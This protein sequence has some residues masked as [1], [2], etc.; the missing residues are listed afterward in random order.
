[1]DISVLAG[2][3]D[4]K[5]S[6]EGICVGEGRFV[7]ERMLH[8][9]LEPLV[10]A[11]VPG[12]LAGL[13]Q[14][15][16][17]PL[18]VQVLPQAEIARIAGYPFHRG[19]LGAF[20]RPEYCSAEDLLGP[21]PGVVLVL[22][23]I[24]DP[25]NLGGILRSAAAFNAGAV[26]LGS[27][28]GDPYSRR[29]IRASM[30]ACFALPIGTGEDPECCLQIVRERGYRIIGADLCPEAE[31]VR[32]ISINTKAVLVLGNEG[33]GISDFWRKGCDGFVS[34]PVSSR[35]DSLNVGVAAGILLY[36]LARKKAT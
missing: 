28:C 33:H 14:I 34:I 3:K 24:T 23:G 19:V 35:V 1:M 10:L 30:A 2:L 20:R 8:E 17:N 16:R 13:Q 21:D 31:L 22:D 11:T 6:E 36:E 32:D 18:P 5:L 15:Y 12:M 25:V 9:G 27:G 4:R 7:V 26:I 29:G